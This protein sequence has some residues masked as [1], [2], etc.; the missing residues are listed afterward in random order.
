MKVD[1][2]AETEKVK[3]VVVET[4]NEMCD[5]CQTK[6]NLL[7]RKVGVCSLLRWCRVCAADVDLSCHSCMRLL[8]LI[9]VFH[10]RKKPSPWPSN[11]KLSLCR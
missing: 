5:H 11:I 6:I 3:S 2:T 1:S 8:H 4:G 7:T 10:E 9:I